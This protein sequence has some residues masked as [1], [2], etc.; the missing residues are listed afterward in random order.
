[1]TALVPGMTVDV[2]MLSVERRKK[3]GVI[4]LQRT[5]PH[6][7]GPGQSQDS[8]WREVPPRRVRHS[9]QEAREPLVACPVRPAKASS[10]RHAPPRRGR[11]RE[12]TFRRS[13]RRAIRRPRPD[14]SSRA[15]NEASRYPGCVPR[16]R[17]GDCTSSSCLRRSRSRAQRGIRNTLFRQPRDRNGP[18]NLPRGESSK[19]SDGVR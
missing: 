15:A 16:D 17:G 2:K 5:K 19:R 18:P 1:M 12:G 14:P 13:K 6:P 3:T 9:S 8:A 11:S 10:Y 7:R 4:F